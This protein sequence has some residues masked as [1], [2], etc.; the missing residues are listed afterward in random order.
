MSREAAYEMWRGKDHPWVSWVKL[1]LFAQA[2]ELMRSVEPPWIGLDTSWLPEKAAVII[3][4]PGESAVSLGLALGLRGVR[5]VLAINACSAPDE[6]VS[7]HA[8][9]DIL[10]M[11]ARFSEAFPTGPKLAPAFI[12]D[13]RRSGGSAHPVF[14]G[15]FDNRWAIFASDLPA[16]HVLREAG[17]TKVI[18]VQFGTKPLDDIEAVLRAY[19]EDELELLLCDLS[20]PGALTALKVV[21]RGWFSEALRSLRRRLSLSRNYQGS[22]GHRVPTEPSHG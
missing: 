16:A 12:L 2:W 13:S 19:Q 5:P 7:M 6:L 11:G 17:L 22:F 14:P 10:A 20:K 3:D 1:A 8:V 9:L 18:V 15:C 21:E 4:L